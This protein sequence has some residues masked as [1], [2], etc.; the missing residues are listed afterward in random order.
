MMK[1]LIMFDFDGTIADSMTMTY[2]IYKD[3]ALKYGM[4]VL[5]KDELVEYKKLPLKE[6]LNKQGIPFYM[7]PKLLSESQ[8]F[9]KKYEEEATLFE[10]MKEVLDSL[11]ETYELVILSS[12]HKKFIKRFLKRHALTHFKKVYGKAALFGKA[13]VIKKVLKKLGYKKLQAIY[14]GD[15]TRD[16]IACNEIGIDIISVSW[17]FDDISLLKSESA[18]MIATSPKEI[19]EYVKSLHS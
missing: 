9:Q 13:G 2:H 1:K 3:M 8:A 5:T 16:I 11:S 12:N 14:I 6:R 4:P 18:K 10:G 19:L 17:G 7:V 15:E